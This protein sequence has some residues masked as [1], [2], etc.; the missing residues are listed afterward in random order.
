MRLSPVTDDKNFKICLL[1]IRSLQKHN[2]GIKHDASLNKYDILALTETQLL[3]HHSDNTITEALHPYALHKQ[4]N[5]TDKYSR[6]ATC[7]K[8]NFNLL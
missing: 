5:P 7:T 3:P 6:L 1:K 2:V 8:N 4:D